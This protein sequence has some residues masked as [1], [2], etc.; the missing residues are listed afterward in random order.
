[1]FTKVILN[2]T[3]WN[4]I[5]PEQFYTTTQNIQNIFYIYTNYSEYFLHLHKLFQTMLH[6]Q[7]ALPLLSH[8]LH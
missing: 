7:I 2:K 1:M 8:E 5:I 3:T 6:L 4:K